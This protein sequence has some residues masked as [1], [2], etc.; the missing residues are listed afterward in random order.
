MLMENLRYGLR[1][2]LKTWK[3]APL[4]HFLLSPRVSAS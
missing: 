3:L 4:R 2:L 1:R